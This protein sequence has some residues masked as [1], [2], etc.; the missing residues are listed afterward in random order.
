[1][2]CPEPSRITFRTRAEVHRTTF[3]STA[4]AVVDHSIP[5][6][7]MTRAPPSIDTSCRNTQRTPPDTPTPTLIPTRTSSPRNPSNRA[8][9]REQ[10]RRIFLDHLKLWSKGNDSSCYFQGSI[11]LLPAESNS[12]EIAL[13]KSVTCILT[14]TTFIDARKT[15]VIR[16][17]PPQTDTRRRIR[18]S[19]HAAKDD[20][21]D[22]CS[23]RIKVTGH[24]KDEPTDVEGHELW[25]PSQPKPSTAN[26]YYKLVIRCGSGWLSAREY[27]NKLYFTH[28]RALK[29]QPGT[30]QNPNHMFALRSEAL[31]PPP[32]QKDTV[33]IQP[34][35]HPFLRLPPELQEMILM[36][37]ASLTRNFN[38]CP[39]EQL[40]PQ[41]PAAR[42]RKPAIS[43]STLLRLS[44][45]INSTMAPHIYRS[46]TFH[47]GNTGFTSFLWQLGPLH[48]PSIR[49]LTFHFGKQSLL[50]C[51]RWLAPTQVHEL[52]EQP[53]LTTPKSMAFFWRCMIQDLAKEVH[54]H[55]LTID[56]RGVE[57]GDVCMVARIM[58]DVFGSVQFVRFVE[59]D[60]LGVTREITPGDER[61]RDLGEKSWRELCRV[62]FARHR[63]EVAYFSAETMKKGE[64]QVEAEMD[65]DKEFFDA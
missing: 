18:D 30:F 55:T 6:S 2:T 34:L 13:G 22:M 50:H 1:V 35:F 45:P 51:I 15:I 43:I 20:V 63:Q 10:Q 37:A 17:F 58:K 33:P 39:N 26:S 57:S 53:I 28:I 29:P 44:K 5:V 59:T 19:A 54:L 38:L 47:F 52:L 62:C 23:T 56:L 41:P 14:D 31:G 24:Q 4:S 8:W 40:F 64:G 11:S 61:L 49:R 25:Q 42:R 48:R 21:M 12:R 32:A 3:N 7:S 27:L 36:T 65:K 16:L 9:V 46:T 60:D